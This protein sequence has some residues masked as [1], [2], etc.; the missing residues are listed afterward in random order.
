M[1]TPKITC[2]KGKMA[3]GEAHN[4]RLFPDEDYFYTSPVCSL[5]KVPGIPL[6]AAKCVASDIVVQSG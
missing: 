6:R 2:E 5:W 3:R 4:K 1:V